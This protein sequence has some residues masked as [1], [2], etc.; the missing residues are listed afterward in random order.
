MQDQVARLRRIRDFLSEAYGDRLVRMY[1]F[2]SRARGDAR[3]D[4]DYDVLVVLESISDMDQE[5]DRADALR[6][7]F[8]AQC[9]VSL[10]VMPR[11][12]EAL[13]DNTT[14]MEDVMADARE[15]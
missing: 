5:Y 11:T 3:P 13:A 12:P 8:L 7:A 1:L 9:D 10:D 6:D 4:S 15:I 14:L 2:G